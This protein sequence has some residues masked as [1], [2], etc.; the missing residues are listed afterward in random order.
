MLNTSLEKSRTR[1]V[2]C[3][4]SHYFAHQILS[5]IYVN[6]ILQVQ[7]T[8]GE[9]VEQMVITDIPNSENQ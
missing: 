2:P 7:R 6:A 5:K 9:Y 1:T 3:Y 8:D 4:A